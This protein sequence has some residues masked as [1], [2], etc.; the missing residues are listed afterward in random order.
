MTTK[1]ENTKKHFWQE[2]KTVVKQPAKAPNFGGTLTL[3]GIK[4]PKTK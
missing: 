3:K 2:E 1:N 4:K